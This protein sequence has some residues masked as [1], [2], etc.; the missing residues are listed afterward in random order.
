VGGWLTSR[1]GRFTARGKVTGIDCIGGWVQWRSYGFGFSVQFI[2]MA[3]PNR[4]SELK[5][6]TYICV[7]TFTVTKFNETLRVN[8]LAT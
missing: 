7:G 1:T 4:N 6:F 8:Y 2:T 5:D 3:D